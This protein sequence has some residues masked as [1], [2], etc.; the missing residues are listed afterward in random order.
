MSDDHVLINRATWDEDA[1]NWVERG[2]I[3]WAMQEPVWGRGVPESELG[4]LPDVSGL[5]TVEIGCGTAFVSSWLARRGA[6]VIALDNSMN[7]LRTARLLQ[8][9]FD[10]RFPLIHA[11]GERPPFADGSFDFAIS[12]HGAATFCDPYRWIPEASRILRRGGRLM[13]ETGSP[14]V[15]LCYPSDDVDAPADASLHRGY[16]G[17]R[18]FEW[19]GPDGAIS[20][21]DFH[22]EHGDM[23][24]LLRRSGFEIDD[25][26]ELQAPAEGGDEW[27]HIS[28]EWA[29]RWPSAEVWKAHKTG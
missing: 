16:F 18:R 27:P 29:R 20:D 6:Y 4:L 5:H 25:L 13:F 2:R 14:L 19:R 3:S 10:L 21:V 1:P 17:M 15:Q 9:E 24:R 7:Q 8:R 22:L 26:I 28:L 12:Q 11:D 23:V